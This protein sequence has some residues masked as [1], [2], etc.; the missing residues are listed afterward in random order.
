MD[1]KT[2]QALTELADKLGTTA[3]YLWGVLVQQ[4]PMSGA[5]DLVLMAAWVLGTG[6]WGRFVL[7]KT[8]GNDPD[9]SHE[10]AF[11]AW[12][13]VTALVVFTTVLVTSC[14][15]TAVSALVHPEYWALRQI[16]Q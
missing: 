1:S 14:L 13:S 5:I 6:T 16:M 2:L 8:A 11:G 10:V 15:T 12:L 9:W 7:H 4:A 3:E